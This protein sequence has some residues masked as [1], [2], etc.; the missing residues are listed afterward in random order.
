[1]KL[2][3]EFSKLIFF[4]IALNNL[5]TI[6]PCKYDEGPPLVQKSNYAG[7]P[8][9][10]VVGIMS[11]NKGCSDLSVPTIYTRLA[12]YYTWLLETAG[13]QPSSE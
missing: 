3:K 2:I 5:E 8:E 4:S 7:I 13:P 1:M 11:K 9:E 6:S 12:T 10:V